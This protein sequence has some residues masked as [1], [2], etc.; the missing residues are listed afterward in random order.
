MERFILY[1]RLVFLS[2]FY[3]PA[4]VLHE[5]FHAL[6]AL[7]TGAKIT[8][9]SL[10]PKLVRNE[11]DGR[12]LIVYGSVSSIPRIAFL[13]FFVAIAPVFLWGILY[14]FLSNYGFVSI[15]LDEGIASGEF[16]YERFFVLENWPLWY[17]AMQLFGGAFLSMQDIKVALMSFFSPS[18]VAV[19]V[20]A[21]LFAFQS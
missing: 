20:T 15:T 5:S 8:R 9:F 21:I 18:G 1:S 11:T 16:D 19:I 13:Q 7:V 14:L 2:I 6:A 17:A 10:F 3:F 12:Y 4:T